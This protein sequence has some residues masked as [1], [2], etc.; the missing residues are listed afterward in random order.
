ML[1][2]VGGIWR[3]LLAAWPGAPRPPCGDGAGGRRREFTEKGV[4]ADDLATFANAESGIDQTLGPRR[5]G[6]VPIGVD[7]CVR[8]SLLHAV[9]PG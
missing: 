7:S 4:S 1:L 6:V 3:L 2:V 9:P 5:K 8:V